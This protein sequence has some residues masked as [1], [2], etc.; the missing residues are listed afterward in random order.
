[1]NANAIAHSIVSEEKAYQEKVHAL[2]AKLGVTYEKALSLIKA[3]AKRKE[4]QQKQLVLAK[5]AR[6]AM[7][8][9]KL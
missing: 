4:Y 9:L 5:A 7:K 8:D 3:E 2:A 1:M 6:K